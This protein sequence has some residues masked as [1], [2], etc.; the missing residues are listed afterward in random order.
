MAQEAAEMERIR[1]VEIA[2]YERGKAAEH[3]AIA[4]KHKGKAAAA[5]VAHSGTRLL[6]QV[7]S[8]RTEAAEPARPT[9]VNRQ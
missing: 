8:T 1:Q 4:M 3:A 9:E 6:G 7:P 5:T 2:Q